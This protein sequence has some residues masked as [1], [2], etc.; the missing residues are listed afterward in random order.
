MVVD[1]N[2]FGRDFYTVFIG[3]ELTAVVLGLFGAVTG[4]SA[5][6]NM[7]ILPAVVIDG[8]AVDDLFCRA[9]DTF[10]SKHRAGRI[11]FK[12]KTSVRGFNGAD[13]NI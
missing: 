5:D 8:P 1:R 10:R 11:I 2:A 13:D 7:L 12:R 9:F 4:G 3:F 6:I